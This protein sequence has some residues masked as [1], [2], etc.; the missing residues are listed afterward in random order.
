MTTIEQ[1]GNINDLQCRRIKSRPQR[2]EPVS[3]FDEKI[4]ADI[5]ITGVK[6]QQMCEVQYTLCPSDRGKHISKSFEYA[7]SHTFHICMLFVTGE[8]VEM[9]LPEVLAVHL[10]QPLKEG[11]TGEMNT[12]FLQALTDRHLQ[13]S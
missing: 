5:D 10:F 6:G 3:L 11:V 7:Q 2:V 4:E 1:A 8:G 9:A 12:I 13:Q